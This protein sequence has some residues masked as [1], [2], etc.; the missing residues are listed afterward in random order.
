MNLDVA[1][2]FLTL[3]GASKSTSR[4]PPK[5]A[6]NSR[7]SSGGSTFALFVLGLMGALIAGGL[8]LHQKGHLQPYMDALQSR[9]AQKTVPSHSERASENAKPPA[10]SGGEGSNS[11]EV[12]K[13]KKESKTSKPPASEKKKAEPSPEKSKPKKEVG[14]ALC[15]CYSSGFLFSYTGLYTVVK[16][17]QSLFDPVGSVSSRCCL[18]QNFI[19]VHVPRSFV[20]FD[21][22][23]VVAGACLFCCLCCRKSPSVSCSKA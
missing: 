14:F 17:Y 8:Y 7:A 12:V 1:L 18:D 19:L 20:Q 6:G 9:S 23:V 10:T 4:K 15:L 13:Q 3:P 2:Y 21:N 22:D 5:S 11:E 16:C